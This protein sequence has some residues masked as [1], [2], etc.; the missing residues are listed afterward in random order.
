[1]SITALL[2]LTLKPESVEASPELIRDVLTATR[3]FAGCEGVEVVI[4]AKD[5]AHVLIIEHWESMDADTAY[6]TWRAT[7]EGAS[8]L[9]KILAAAPVLTHWN[10][11][12]G[13]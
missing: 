6:R 8:G 9:G 12:P 7:P 3:A 1:M 4:D 13:V 5:P 2:E 11:A 10:D